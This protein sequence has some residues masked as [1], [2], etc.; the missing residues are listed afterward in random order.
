M[1]IRF[2]SVIAS[3]KSE[4]LVFLKESGS[5][6]PLKTDLHESLKVYSVL[7]LLMYLS[8]IFDGGVCWF[9]ILAECSC[10]FLSTTFLPTAESGGLAGKAGGAIFV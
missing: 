7:E 4:N 2:P 3:V 1:F 5:C 8:L 9:S 10:S 6:S